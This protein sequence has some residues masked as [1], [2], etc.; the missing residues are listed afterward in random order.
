MRRRTYDAVVIGSGSIGVPTAWALARDGLSVLVLD[1]LPSTGQGSNKTAIG[2]IRA[3]HSDPAKIRL[4]L[5]SLEIA[6][7]WR[8]RYGDDIEWTTGGYA[9]VATGEREEQVLKE[10]LAVQ[11]RYGLDI[12]WLERREL[13]DVVPTLRREIVR[14]GTYSPADGH[15]S[16]LLFGHA[17]FRQ[18]KAA[19]VEFRFGEAARR[20]ERSADR[21]CAVATDKSLYATRT[22]VN[23]AGAWAAGVGEMAGTEHPVRPDAHEAGITE[24]VAPFLRPMV[25]DI[26]PSPGSANYYFF[27]LATGQ[28]VFCVTPS[29]SVWGF[30]RRETSRFLPLVAR[31]MVDLMPCLANLRVR[32]TWRGLYPMT[33][34][35]SPIV[36]QSKDIEGYVMAIGMCGQGFML[37]PGVGE[38][39]SRV[40][41][42]ET[43]REDDEVLTL[44]SPHRAFSRAEVLK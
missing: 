43:T 25:V 13:L 38:L 15:C 1:P 27:Q 18:A 36:G 7:T 44:L 2:G 16:P 5:R 11:V 29:P 19:G 33:P 9:F 21:V 39:V 20:I 10:L 14:G 26:R 6:S 31:R 4:G 22:V 24:P 32:R 37:G 35:G 40:V 8:E 23:A 3:T 41:R 12:A 28:V 34:D 42:R 17:M 30:D